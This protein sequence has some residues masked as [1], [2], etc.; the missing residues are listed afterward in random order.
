METI[1]LPS[2]SRYYLTH[3]SISRSY[4][5]VQTAWKWVRI[6]CN[7]SRM[8]ICHNFIE[9]LDFSIAIIDHINSINFIY[10]KWANTLVYLEL[11]GSWVGNLGCS[12]L[13]VG[14]LRLEL[15]RGVDSPFVAQVSI[16][17]WFKF[18]NHIY[19]LGSIPVQS[20]NIIAWSFQSL[21][22]ILFAYSTA[23]CKSWFLVHFRWFL[24]NR[25]IFS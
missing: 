22:V 11:T 5:P 9:C 8:D 7:M 12:V 13:A 2:D 24:I 20:L 16:K 14:V 17:Y 4:P 15:D 1:V 21:L 3:F 23:S 18:G 6:V 19:K 25:T 10:H